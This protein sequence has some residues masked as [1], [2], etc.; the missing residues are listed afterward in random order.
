ME[1][2]KNGVFDARSACALIA[3]TSKWS[4][5]DIFQV[6]GRYLTLLPVDGSSLEKGMP[7]SR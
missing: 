2:R 1:V 4:V 3:A 5:G 6:G 7:S